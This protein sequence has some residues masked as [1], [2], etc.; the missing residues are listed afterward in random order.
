[1][2]QAQ[3]KWARMIAIR[4]NLDTFLENLSDFSLYLKIFLSKQILDETLKFSTCSF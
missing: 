3:L 4:Q 2:K 1:M